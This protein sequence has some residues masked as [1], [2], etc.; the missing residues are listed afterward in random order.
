MFFFCFQV[1]T[2]TD[3]IVLN[4]LDLTINKASVASS[5]SARQD[6]SQI[7]SNGDLETLTLVFPNEVPAGRAWLSLE[8]TGEIN[9]KMKGLYR[10]KYTRF[11]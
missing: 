7:T 5:G 4:C 10:S 6:A 2:P 9:D 1:K 11:V 3:S 8:F